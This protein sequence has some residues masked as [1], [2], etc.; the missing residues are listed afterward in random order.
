MNLAKIPTLLITNIFVC[1]L[2]TVYNDF[3]S[4]MPYSY[5]LTFVMP[6]FF[7]LYLFTKIILKKKK[8]KRPGNLDVSRKVYDIV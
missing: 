7:V 4:F 8:K 3:Y 1:S 2:N 5:I 6:G